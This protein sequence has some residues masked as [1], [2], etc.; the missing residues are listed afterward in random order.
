MKMI[1]DIEYL[2]KEDEFPVS[3]WAKPTHHGNQPLLLL[4]F[5]LI[6]L[7]LLVGIVLATGAFVVEVLFHKHKRQEEPMSDPTPA[8]KIRNGPHAGYCGNKEMIA[9]DIA[10]K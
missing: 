10:N 5:I 7:H 6:F 3:Y 9:V 8:R 1:R 2:M 4:P